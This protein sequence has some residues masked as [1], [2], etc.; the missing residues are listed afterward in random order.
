MEIFEI[1]KQDFHLKSLLLQFLWFQMLNVLFQWISPFEICIV[2][3]LPCILVCYLVILRRWCN[4][5]WRNHWKFLQIVVRWGCLGGLR[6]N[7]RI[8]CLHCRLFQ[9]LIHLDLDSYFDNNNSISIIQIGWISVFLIFLLLLNFHLLLDDGL[10]SFL[11]MG[12]A[13]DEFLGFLL[14]SLGRT[15][16]MVTLGTPQTLEHGLT[17]FLGFLAFVAIMEGT[18]EFLCN[19]IHNLEIATSL[20]TSKMVQ[21]VAIGNIAFKEFWL[22]LFDSRSGGSFT[23]NIL[24]D[25]I[26]WIP[27]IGNHQIDSRGTPNPV[28]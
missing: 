23:N 14:D 6:P 19:T 20:H 12:G 16:G 28:I 26:K 9:I 1:F 13:E 11:T 10:D 27:P 17:L 21:F 15:F 8:G 4:Y 7:H 22:R 24:M 5:A 18:F 3:K 2:W 25:N